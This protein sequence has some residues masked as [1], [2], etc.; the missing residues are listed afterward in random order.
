MSAVNGLKMLKSDSERKNLVERLISGKLDE[1]KEEL[2]ED[3]KVIINV[4]QKVVES[5]TDDEKKYM[6]ARILW[7]SE[8]HE[9]DS[10]PGSLWNPANKGYQE[11]LREINDKGIPDPSENGKIFIRWLENG[12][13]SYTGGDKKKMDKL[14]PLLD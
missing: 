10:P 3:D 11:P 13:T 12:E 4:D 9:P 8:R 7:I 5:F 14:L 6:K 1:E 2:E